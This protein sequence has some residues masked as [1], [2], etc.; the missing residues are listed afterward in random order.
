MPNNKLPQRIPLVG[1]PR[2]EIRGWWNP[3]SAE[4]MAQVIDRLDGQA[5]REESSR[6]R[7]VEAPGIGRTNDEVS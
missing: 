6:C 2:P 5:D 1:P 3:P 4:V 7:G